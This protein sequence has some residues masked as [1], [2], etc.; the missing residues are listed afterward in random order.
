MKKVFY[1]L[2]ILPLMAGLTAC[3]NNDE[4]NPDDNSSDVKTTYGAYIVNTG[5]WNQND[6]SI[7]WY[8]L[9]TKEISGDIYN[10]ENKKG[11]GDLQDLCIYGSK[12]YAISTTSSKIEI[13]ERNG[14]IVKTI[15]MVNEAG[16][17]KSPRYA[18]AADG[19]VFV[20]AQDGTVSKIDTISMSIVATAQV[21]GYLEGL[22]YNKGKLFVNKSDYMSDGT[23]NSVYVIDTE[24]ME[25]IKDIT[26]VLNPYTQ[27]IVGSD[28]YIYIV[29]NGNYAGA[30]WLPGE[31][32]WI[33][34]T[35]QRINPDT[36]EVEE[37]CNAS[38][39]AN[40]GDK[41]YILYSEYYLPDRAK[42]F[43]Y[44]IKTKEEKEFIDFSS[45]STPGG[46]AVDP[47]SDDVYIISNPYGQM[48]EVF[49]YDN[50]GNFKHKFETGAYTT[51]I[52]FLSE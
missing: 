13:L 39:I 22:S 27:N 14:K 44:D 29:S 32:S 15:S 36:Y 25:K 40:R 49:V 51:N 2:A 37:L 6:A 21:G 9:T 24:T 41:M 47:N 1:Y 35:L 34:G 23:G 33:Y 11:I 43:V 30:E 46:I 48:S 38:Y 28:G 17:P 3:E 8:D 31:E 12:L 19:Y 10:Q 42:C 4:P 7:Q 16:Q 18:T 5:N 52:K 20:S 50:E 26:V 45:I